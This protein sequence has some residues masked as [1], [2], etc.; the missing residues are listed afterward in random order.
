MFRHESL[1]HYARTLLHYGHSS[2]TI[3]TAEKEEEHSVITATHILDRMLHHTLFHQKVLHH[4]IIWNI[5]ASKQKERYRE[6][7]RNSSAISSSFLVSPPVSPLEE[8]ITKHLV[9]V[10][11]A[12]EEDEDTTR[13][14]LCG[15]LVNRHLHSYFEAGV[16]DY[17]TKE[18]EAHHWNIS[19]IFAHKHT[20]CGENFNL[21]ICCRECNVRMKTSTPLQCARRLGK[22]ERNSLAMRERIDTL[23]RAYVLYFLYYERGAEEGHYGL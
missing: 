6:M 1:R 7:R 9:T 8:A 22:N 18:L 13:C 2:K 3:V 20:K 11:S 10:A 16:W 21:R 5:F 17:D 4:E 15:N 12:A 19:H 14:Y 23:T